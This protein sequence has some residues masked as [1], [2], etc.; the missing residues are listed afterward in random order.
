MVKSF[1]KRIDHKAVFTLHKNHY[2]LDQSG[3]YKL[4]LTNFK[5]NEMIKFIMP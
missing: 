1:K 2:F 3:K 5:D 4:G